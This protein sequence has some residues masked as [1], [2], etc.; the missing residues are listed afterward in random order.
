MIYGYIG[1]TSKVDYLSN[2]D[3]MR[4]YTIYNYMNRNRFDQIIF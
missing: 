1:C 3:D 4:S 2:G